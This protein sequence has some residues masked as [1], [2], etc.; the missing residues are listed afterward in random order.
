MFTGTDSRTPGGLGQVT[1]VSPTKVATTLT[2]TLENLFVVGTLTLS[3]VPEPGTFLL[4]GS[5]VAGLA[6]RGRRRMGR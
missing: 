3:F 2:G 5:G 6:M 4:L 1:L